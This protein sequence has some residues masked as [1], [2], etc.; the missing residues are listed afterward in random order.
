MV[1]ISLTRLRVLGIALGLMGLVVFGFASPLWAQSAKID[2][3]YLATLYVPLDPPQVVAK[4]LFI[5][6]VPADREG[7]LKGPKISGK[8]IQPCGDWLHAHPNG[9][10]WLDV[11]CTIRADDGS[12]IYVEYSGVIGWRVALHVTVVKLTCNE[13]GGP[14]SSSW[15][16]STHSQE[17]YHG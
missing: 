10:F 9:N 4:D 8:P 13:N 3:E 5:Y 1:V 2:T 7:Y 16:A 11:R 12:L 17:D 6:N 14:T 15:P